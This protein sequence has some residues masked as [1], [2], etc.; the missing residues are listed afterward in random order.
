MAIKGIAVDDENLH[1][2]IIGLNR[3]DVEAILAGRVVSLPAGFLPNLT[4]QSDVVVMFGETDEELEQRFG[5]PM[6]PA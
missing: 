1:H 4:E 5:P 2:L 6:R 3:Q